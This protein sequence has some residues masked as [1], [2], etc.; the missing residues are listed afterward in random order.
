MKILLTGGG[1]RLGTELRA[2][3][4]GIVAPT[5]GEMNITDAGQVLTTAQREQPDL[6]VH[7]AAY[8]NV[9]GAEKDRRLLERQRHRHPEYGSRRQRRERQTGAHQHR[10]R[11]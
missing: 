6:I 9:G 4:P 2:L 8:T 3:L 10:L 1:G 7:A 5:S 11:V